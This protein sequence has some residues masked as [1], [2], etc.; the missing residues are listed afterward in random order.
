MKDWK[1]D[2]RDL[3]L[4]VR[5]QMI[6][7]I[8][9]F[10]NRIIKQI[11]RIEVDKRDVAAVSGEDRRQ[12]QRLDYLKQ[13]MQRIEEIIRTIENTQPNLRAN[14]VKGFSSEMSDLEQTIDVKDQEMK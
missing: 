3:I 14:I 2:I 11:A 10:T 1:E 5:T 13:K 9:N 4:R 8:D 6:A 7:F 12:E